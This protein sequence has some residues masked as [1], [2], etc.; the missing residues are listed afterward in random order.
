MIVNRNRRFLRG[1]E[2]RGPCSASRLECD[3]RNELIYRCRTLATARFLKFAQIAPADVLFT[4]L[5]IRVFITLQPEAK[6]IQIALVDLVPMF[7]LVLDVSL[8]WID[9]HFERL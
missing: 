9:E 5:R 6:P 3:S 1:H 4:L 2:I 7:R 8:V